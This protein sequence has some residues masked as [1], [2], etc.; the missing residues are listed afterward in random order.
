MNDL[1]ASSLPVLLV[2][3]D[4][5][6][7]V[8]ER[9][10]LSRAG[11]TVQVATSVRSAV[12]QLRQQAFCAVLLDHRLPDG[13]SW[14]VVDAAR[15]RVPPVPVI[16][17]TGV[18]SEQIAV[19]AIQHGVSD[20]VKKSETFFEQLPRTVKRVARLAE[21]EDELRRT[22]A[23]FSLIENTALEVITVS[24]GEGVIK[25]IS[26]ACR[27]LL[28]YEP[29]ELIGTHARDLVHPDDQARTIVAQ[30]D[31]HSEEHMLT[32]YRCRKKDGSYI[33]LEVSAKVTAHSD[34][35]VQE[36]VGLARDVTEREHATRVLEQSL[37]EKEV[38]LK[39]IHH[40]VK[41]NLQVIASLIN[42]QSRR[43]TDPVARA[44]FEDTRSRV[45]AIALLH[46]RLYS[47]KDLA[48]IDV[49]DYLGGLVQQLARAN[50]ED[51][52]TIDVRVDAVNIHYD[53]DT[54]VPVGLIVNELVTNAFKHAFPSGQRARGS[55]RV[56]VRNEL[57][58]NTI[59]VQDDGVGFPEA[60]DLK[61]TSSLGMLLI[62]SL[63]RQLAGDVVIERGPGARCIVTFPDPVAPGA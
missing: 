44:L 20:Y 40:R 6:T 36:I 9:R 5:T 18:G 60:L 27:R 33:W 54:A 13:D 29:A 7:L 31:V 3:D 59:V 4:E 17:V 14:P 51:G 32:S 8:L 11:L 49:A 30:A 48:R 26:P 53:I 46:E 41:N 35:K 37:A 58:R 39:E 50:K 52:R 45:H 1:V 22:S 2:E 57:G 62:T 43:V 56:E 55:I 19:E 28:G 25:Y 42:L 15:A 38:L 47:T 12:E 23:L 63:S 61:Q 21:A 10:A 24:N 16:L 34:G